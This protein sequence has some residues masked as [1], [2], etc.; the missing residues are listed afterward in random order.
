MH[1]FRSGRPRYII[2]LEHLILDHSQVRLL[3][4]DVLAPRLFLECGI[5]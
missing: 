3:V 2:S 4:V 1:I 5:Q